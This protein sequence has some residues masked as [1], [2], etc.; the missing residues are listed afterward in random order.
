MFMSYLVCLSICLSVC[1]SVCLSGC[2]AVCC[3]SFSCC[4]SF[5]RAKLLKTSI[6]NV[7][8][9]PSSP[10]NSGWVSACR[11]MESYI[12]NLKEVK[13]ADIDLE[14][15]P[16]QKKRNS[17]QGCIPVRVDRIGVDKENS[18]PRH[19]NK[20][21]KAK[22]SRHVMTDSLSPGKQSK[23]SKRVLTKQNGQAKGINSSEFLKNSIITATPLIN[24][25]CVA[26]DSENVA[27]RLQSD[28]YSSS[29]TGQETENG[30]SASLMGKEQTYVA[31]ADGVAFTFVAA[32]QECRK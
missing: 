25:N 24:V 6:Q 21:S 30:W 12:S 18:N 16:G 5:L 23:Q 7:S 14:I 20:K 11:E 13:Y 15:F 3:L 4:L 27:K 22:P 8:N 32:V 1:L 26:V 29:R 17:E 9:I 10:A 28:A 19:K 2:L 31:S